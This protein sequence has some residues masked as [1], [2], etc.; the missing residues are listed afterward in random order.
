MPL[1]TYLRANGHPT[2]PIVL[3]EG[4]MYGADWSLGNKS[5]NDLKNVALSAEYT[6]L[7]AMG[8]ANLH[9]A[10]TE[11]I[12]SAPIVSAEISGPLIDATV[13]GTHLTD[14]GMRKQSAFWV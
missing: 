6:K 4:T 9:Y 5:N 11:D 12:T 7:M 14:L 10:K 2:T 1:V 13:G 8:V 3:S